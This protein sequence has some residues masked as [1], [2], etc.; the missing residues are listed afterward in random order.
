MR[1][2]L[3]NEQTCYCERAGKMPA[4]QEVGAVAGKMPALQEVGAV[5][6]KM[7]ALQYLLK[8]GSVFALIASCAFGGRVTLFVIQQSATKGE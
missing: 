6:G 2:S 5:A 7:P 8:L 3:P 4:L 1:A